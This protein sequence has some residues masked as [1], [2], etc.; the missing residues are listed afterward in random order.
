MRARG[1]QRPR[2]GRSGTAGPRDGEAA[3]QE[4]RRARRLLHRRAAG[5]GDRRREGVLPVGLELP[6]ARRGTSAR[7]PQRRELQ[8]GRHRRH[9]RSAGDR[10]RRPGLTRAAADRR[11]RP[12]HPAGDR[13]DRRQRRGPVQ[14]A[15]RDVCRG[16]RRELRGRCPG[17][18][19]RPRPGAGADRRQ[20]DPRAAAGG[21]PSAARRGGARRLPADRRGGPVVPGHADGAR[22]PPGARAAREGA[23]VDDGLRGP[24]GRRGLRRHVRRVQG[25]R[26][27]LEA[28][29]GSTAGPWTSS[30]RLPSI[31]SRWARRPSPTA[32]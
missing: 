30:A 28:T 21:P 14:D 29:R 2:A 12:E 23:G 24:A 1:V 8:R 11:G 4:V 3:L 27:L 7:A 9:H 20:R 26:G 22:R 17:G 31:R 5:A 10:P 19:R 25:P 13:R 16:R 18:A 6:G 32:S 15:G